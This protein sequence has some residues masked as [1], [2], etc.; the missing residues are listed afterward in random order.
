[1][2]YIIFLE[3]VTI[4]CAYTRTVYNLFINPA[5]TPVE[6]QNRQFS[7][8]DMF[9]STLAAMGVKI[10]GDR[11]ALGTNLFSEK[12]T[13]IEEYGFDET[14]WMLFCHEL[15]LY[16]TVESLEG[17]PY[18]HLENVHLYNHIHTLHLDIQYQLK[19]LIY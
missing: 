7:T 9:P 4:I 19:Y 17:V 12:K 5:V 8:L 13:L 3:N 6:T 15:S 11:L 16:V 14:K 10:D 2:C 1:M 18:N